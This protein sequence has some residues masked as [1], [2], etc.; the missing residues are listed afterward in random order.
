M[1]IE[2]TAAIFAKSCEANGEPRWEMCMEHMSP[3]E[4][5]RRCWAKAKADVNRNVSHASDCATHN[6]PALPNGRCDCGAENPEVLA[7]R[8]A[9]KSAA[10]YMRDAGAFMDDFPEITAALSRIPKEAA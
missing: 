4:F 6:E 2:Q 9:L 8:R 1:P 7:L 5:C 3:D 10:A